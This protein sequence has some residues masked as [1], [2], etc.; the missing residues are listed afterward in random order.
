[1]THHEERLRQIGN[2]LDKL[3]RSVRLATCGGCPLTYDLTVDMLEI[4]EALSIYATTNV[5]EP[6]SRKVYGGL[7]VVS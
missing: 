1:M 7:R 3:T 4:L 2:Q 5:A 6:T